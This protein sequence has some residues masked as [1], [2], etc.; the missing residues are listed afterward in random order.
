MRVKLRADGGKGVGEPQSVSL[1]WS[2]M[3]V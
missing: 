2:G 3:L 1:D